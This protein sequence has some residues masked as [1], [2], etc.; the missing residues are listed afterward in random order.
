MCIRDRVKVPYYNEWW[1]HARLVHLRGLPA[2]P[3]RDVVVPTPSPCDRRAQLPRPD[4]RPR[5]VVFIMFSYCPMPTKITFNFFSFQIPAHSVLQGTGLL[6]IA[7][8]PMWPVRHCNVISYYL[9][10]QSFSTLVE[11]HQFVCMVMCY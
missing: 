8:M 11:M 4:G 5:H 6:G 1:V 3:I 7:Q 2:V 10:M 9:V